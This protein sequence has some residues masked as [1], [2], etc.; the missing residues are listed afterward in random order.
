MWVGGCSK[1]ISTLFELDLYEWSFFD[2]LSKRRGEKKTKASRG[3]W[4]ELGRNSLKLSP[5][6][7]ITGCLS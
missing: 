4:A 6:S 2:Q 3:Q 5:S 7:L 1:N